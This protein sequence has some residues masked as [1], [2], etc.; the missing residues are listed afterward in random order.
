MHDEDIEK[1]TFKTHHG[2]FEF[3]LM[4]FSLTNTPTSF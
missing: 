2:H 1:T 3:L 4:S